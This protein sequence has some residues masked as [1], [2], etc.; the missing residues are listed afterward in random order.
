M[1]TLQEKTPNEKVLEA[2]YKDSFL[3]KT[4]AIKSLKTL[5]K[6]IDY[7]NKEEVIKTIPIVEKLIKAIND[8][9]N[10]ILEVEKRTNESQL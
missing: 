10:N 4:T 6:T 7:S 3:V 1:N 9:N 2:V 8:A 5:S